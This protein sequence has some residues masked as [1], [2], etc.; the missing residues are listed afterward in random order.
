M[1]VKLQQMAVTIKEA[2]ESQ[3]SSIEDLSRKLG[4]Q[5]ALKTKKIMKSL[6]TLKKR[7]RIL[8]NEESE[9]QHKESSSVIDAF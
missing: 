7:P 6:Q 5:M 8:Y 1:A 9:Y 4:T 2:T 3:E